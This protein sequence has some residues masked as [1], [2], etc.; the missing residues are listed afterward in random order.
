MLALLLR[1][2]PVKPLQRL[3]IA[4][5]LAKH[6]TVYEGIAS[7]FFE[8]SLELTFLSKKVSFD[9]LQHFLYIADAMTY[10]DKDQ[11][12]SLWNEKDGMYYDAIIFGPVHSTQL[13]IRSL[14]GLIPLFATLVLE[15]SVLNRFPRFKKRMEAFI[16]N[17]PDLAARNIANMKSKL[18][19]SGSSL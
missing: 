13:P 6:N 3:S 10:P 1:C 15:P 16:D 2:T 18:I 14:V 5:E 9:C 17:R 8:V 4:L 19:C 11:G 12:Q 7:K